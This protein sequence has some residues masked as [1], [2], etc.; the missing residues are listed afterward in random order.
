MGAPNFAHPQNA[1]K[2][3][4]VLTDRE[5]KYKKC[6]S[7]KEKHYEWEFDLDIL[8]KCNNCNST[9][10]K[11]KS[12]IQ[13]PDEWEYEDLKSNIGHSLTGIGG[14][15]L[16]EPYGHDNSYHRQV[17][18]SL[19]SSKSFGDIEVEIEIKVVVQSAYYEGATLD[20]LIFVYNG[21]ENVELNDYYK[22][23]S[24]EVIEDLFET[25]Y[26]SHNYSEMSRGLRVIQSKH[27]ENWAEK[28]IQEMSTKI[29]TIL[30]QYSEHK[31]QR[32]GVFSNGEAVYTEV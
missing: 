24:H 11:S 4:V 10:L 5:I 25:K 17:V 6:K 16:D 27:A 26:S 15:I 18:G 2:Y 32:Q 20:Y 14:D 19:S 21:S 31:L 13:S 22:I 12:K 9:K 23:T 8:T 3:F 1:S 28:E 7:C 29:E 30:E